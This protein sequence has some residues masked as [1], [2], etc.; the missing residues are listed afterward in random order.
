MPTGN[1]L[2]VEAGGPARP[3]ARAGVLSVSG[4]RVRAGLGVHHVVKG[5]GGIGHRSRS[6]YRPLSRMPR[7]DRRPVRQGA[8]DRNTLGQGPFSRS[9]SS[10][11]QPNGNSSDL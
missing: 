9:M 4:V 1:R 3:G 7:R 11:G 6:P 10:N 8:A 5:T 2:P